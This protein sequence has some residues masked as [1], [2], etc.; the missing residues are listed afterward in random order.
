LSFLYSRHR[1]FLH[2]IERNQ[3]SNMSSV[4]VKNSDTTAKNKGKGKKHR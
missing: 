1:A 2:N 3:L 4:R